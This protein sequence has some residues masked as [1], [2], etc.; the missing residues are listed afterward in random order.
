M[1]RKNTNTDIYLNWLWHAPN[2]WKR[3]T[4][5]VMINRTYKLCSTDYHL[6]EE[7]RY[8]EKVFVE[9]NNY[10]R[11]LVKQMMKKILD[12]KTNR[13]VPNVTINLPNEDRRRSIKTPLISLPYKGKQGENVIRFLR[14]TLDKILP[15][16]V[17]PKFI[18]TGTK[19]SAKF[20]IKDKTKDEHK[21]D[22]VYYGKSRM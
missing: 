7:L 14:N 11:W 6:K 22:L 17:E 9:R 5:K 8:L 10:P 16:G 1:Y 2:T 18:H 20:Q 12:E 13:N 4:L 15:Q 3:G 21:R 19:L